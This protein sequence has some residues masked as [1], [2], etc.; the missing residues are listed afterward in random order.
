MNKQII[1]DFIQKMRIEN[2][3]LQNSLP[4]KNLVQLIRMIE[5][6]G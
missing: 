2:S 4:D 5:Q 6:L 3:Q 1:I